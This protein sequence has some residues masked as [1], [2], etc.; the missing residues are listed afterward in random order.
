M[1]TASPARQ[2]D[3]TDVTDEEEA[4]VAPCSTLMDEERSGTT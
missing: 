1:E 4:V 2:P 3:P